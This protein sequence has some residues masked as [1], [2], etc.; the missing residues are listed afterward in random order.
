[1]SHN[2]FDKLTAASL[3][4][5]GFSVCRCGIG[6]RVY[7][8][9]ID[10]N[11]APGKFFLTWFLRGNGTFR[12]NGTDYP[13]HDYSACLRRAD[14]PYTMDL[15]N[16]E[17][18]RLFLTLSDELFHLLQ[19]LIPELETIP[20]VW[21]HPFSQES[22]DAFM[23]FYNRLEQISQIEFYQLIPDLVR[24]ILLIT[25]IQQHRTATPLENGR[26][27]L[28]ENYSLPLEKIAEKCNMTYH[29]FRRQFTERYGMSPGKYRIQK[30]IEKAARYIR[31]GISVSDTAEILGYPDIYTFSHQFHSVK[32]ISPGKYAAKHSE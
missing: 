10:H 4:T 13:L 5:R 26:K 32:G 19:I 9:H 30:R 28:E 17:G 11:S 3:P 16:D 7:N 25:G 31:Q 21:E 6:R 24:Y 22:F 29:T 1:M 8:Q 12:Q 2:F 27:I 23:S 20:P 15:T 18:P 14:I